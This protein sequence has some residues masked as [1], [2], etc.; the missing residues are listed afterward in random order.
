MTCNLRKLQLAENSAAKI[1]KLVFY[2]TV[3]DF[4]W[5]RFWPQLVVLE[6]MLSP[7]QYIEQEQSFLDSSCEEGAE[8]TWCIDS[9]SRYEKRCNVAVCKNGEH[10][11]QVEKETATSMA[12][13]ISLLFI[14]QLFNV[15]L[16]G[17][18][19]V[20]IAA[21]VVFFTS[22]KTFDASLRNI[23]CSLEPH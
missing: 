11:K 23:V 19:K 13:F 4:G 9:L 10:H 15:C 7:S 3:F 20:R 16:R 1:H 12:C 17:S 6:T 14:F 22:S 21:L 18:I 2:I 5:N 8:I